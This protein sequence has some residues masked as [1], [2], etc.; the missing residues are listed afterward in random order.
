[1]KAMQ[2][3]LAAG[4]VRNG[5]QYEFGMQK[6]IEKWFRCQKEYRKNSEGFW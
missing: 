2:F 5:I 4:R 1:M 3:R 6:Q